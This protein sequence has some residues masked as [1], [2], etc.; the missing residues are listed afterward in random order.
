M[1]ITHWMYFVTKRWGYEKSTLVAST[2]HCLKT[3]Y[4]YSINSRQNTAI[5]MQPMCSHNL[6]QGQDP[7]S[8]T[9]ST[10]SQISLAS[11]PH[12]L[13]KCGTLAWITGAVLLSKALFCFVWNIYIFF[14]LVF[15]LEKN[16]ELILQNP[17]S[18]QN[19]SA[20]S[21]LKQLFNHVLV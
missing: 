4:Y 14:Q 1:E 21:I 16:Q 17:I 12:M 13:G 3:T 6:T 2:A 5:W 11:K 9:R 20:K 19:L 18:S 15:I 10:Q 8:Y 7:G